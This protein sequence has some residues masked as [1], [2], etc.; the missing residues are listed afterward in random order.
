MKRILLGV[1]SAA[2]LLAAAF[3]NP[4]SAADM[5][6]K[7]PPAAPP[8]CVW[9]GW[10]IGVEGGGGWGHAEDTDATG[11]D[12][13]RFKV[14][15][16]LA[17]GTVGYN[18]QIN[19]AVLGLEGDGSWANIKGSTTGTVAAVGPCGGAPSN[20]NS[21]L[22]ALGTVR[23]RLGLAYGNFMPFVSGGLAIGSLH[24][25]EGTTLAA[26][27]VGSGT[28]TVTGWTAGGGVEALLG[29][30]WSLKVEYLFVDL[31]N[32][33]I[34]ND[35]LPALGGAVFAERVKLTTNIVRAGI[36]WHFH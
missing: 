7:A 13:G 16:G 14:S 30:A 36:N 23:G 27:A 31:G 32:H 15:G 10:Y 18:W 2:M 12:S 28:T 6:V 11:F 24:G 34:F 4:A 20:C 19:Q 9:C 29:G 8:P 1:A 3:S 25:S 22:Q 5:A 21:N 33:A 26:G 35:T 17:G